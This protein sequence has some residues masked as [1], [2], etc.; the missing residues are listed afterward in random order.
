MVRVNYRVIS[1]FS[2]NCAFEKSNWLSAASIRRLREGRQLLDVWYDTSFYREEIDIFR[3]FID[4][5]FFSIT[6]FHVFISIQTL[7]QI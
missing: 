4:Q 7:I 2:T 1:I 6:Y 5:N 3:D